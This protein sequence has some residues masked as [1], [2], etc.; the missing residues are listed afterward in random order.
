MTELAAVYSLFDHLS[1]GFCLA[2]ANGDVLYINDAAKKLLELS[3]PQRQ[4]PNLCGLLCERLKT[5]GHFAGQ[6]CPL[7][8]PRDPVQAVTFAGSHGPRASFNWADDRVH[9]ADRFRDL[10][11]RCLRTKLA[12]GGPK[13]EEVHVVMLEDATDEME[14]KRHRADWRS[15]IAHDLRAPLSG[16]FSALRLLE[17][18]HP[19]KTAGLDKLEG[20]SDLVNLALRNCRRMMELLDLYLDVA[21]LD[22]AMMQVKLEEIDL[23]GLIEDQVE[24]QR[25]PASDAGVIVE[26]DVPK[27]VKPK[28]DAELLARVIGN[29]VNNAIKYNVKGGKV[30]ITAGVDEHGVVLMVGDTGK[31]ISEVDLPHIFDRFYQAEAR[32]AGR[33]KGNGLGLTFCKEALGLMHGEIGVKSK[34]GRGSEFIVR[35]PA[36]GSR[37]KRP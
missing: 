29:L 17:E 23:Q 19:K 12:F 27:D 18:I 30:S 15:M 2:D 20:D 35:L 22:A 3:G 4:L 31:G 9:R 32:R 7:R 1:D 10:R 13:E 16:I 26:V 6:N 21:Q 8:D 37:G 24:A 34:V 28:A 11:V 36:G 14:L 25:G 5:N 33:I